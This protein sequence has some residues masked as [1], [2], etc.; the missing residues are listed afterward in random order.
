MR[1]FT[2]AIFI[3]TVPMVWAESV[4]IIQELSRVLTARKLEPNP[5]PKFNE[6]EGGAQSF[7]S[8]CPRANLHPA[9]TQKNLPSGT[10]ATQVTALTIYLFQYKSTSVL[11][12]MTFSDWLCYS[13]SPLLDVLGVFTGCLAPLAPI[14]IPGS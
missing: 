3:V 4:P 10:P 13:L 14:A 8:F 1:S 5:K 6:A 7:F 12:R 2:N 11:S 9:R